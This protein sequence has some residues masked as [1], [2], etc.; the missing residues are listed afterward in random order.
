MKSGL[1]LPLPTMTVGIWD[2]INPF[3]ASVSIFRNQ[4]DDLDC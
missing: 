1:K 2:T 4:S 3:N